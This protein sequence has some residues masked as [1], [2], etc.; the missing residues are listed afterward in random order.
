MN[1]IKI[2]TF[3]VLLVTAQLTYGGSFYSAPSSGGSIATSVSIEDKGIYNLVVSVQFLNE[4]FD[5]APYTS[6]DYEEM[7][8]RLNVMWRGVVL[9]RVLGQSNY[10]VSDLAGLKQ[11]IDEDIFQLVGEARKKHGV[12]ASAEVVYSIGSFYL[13][14]LNKE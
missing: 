3:F 7:I 10:K 14:N 6:E 13:V 5:K 8:N 12:K 9:K 11:K 2:W 4:P 1:N